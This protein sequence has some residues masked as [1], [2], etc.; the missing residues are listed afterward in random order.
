MRV[1]LEP[2]FTLLPVGIG[3]APDDLRAPV[4]CAQAP[5]HRQGAEEDHSI[6]GHDADDG[7]WGSPSRRQGSQTDGG[8]RIGQAQVIREDGVSADGDGRGEVNC[9]QR[10]ELVWTYVPGPPKYCLIERV[11]SDAGECHRNDSLDIRNCCPTQRAP[12]LEPRER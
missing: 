11:L 12:D 8:R 6:W 10:A 5:V 4:S 9:I 1:T 3:R 2:S 7:C